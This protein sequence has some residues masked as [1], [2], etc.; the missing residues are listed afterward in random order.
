LSKIF[1]SG[2]EVKY[3]RVQFQDL[4][5]ISKGKGSF[6]VPRFPIK[7]EKGKD[8]EVEVE[9]SIKKIKEPIAEKSL[10]LEVIKEEAH[11]KGKVA[12]RL[13]A[14]EKLHSATQAL[15]AG[16]EQI[17]CL[18]K[19]LLI[20]SKEDML[21]LIMA[22]VKR[23]IHTEIE[24]KGDIIVKTLTKALQA[25]V[26]ADKYYIR[27]HPEDLNIVTEKEPLFLASM[28][29]LQNIYFLADE[30]VSRGGCFAESQAGEVDA[31]IESQLN[32]I[33]EHLR[34]EIV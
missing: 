14:E 29:G 30:T 18:R 1:R 23:V 6:F 26:Q 7:P 9:T 4:E 3:A 33:Y 10:N 19:S 17:S 21:R 25:A 22:V 27:V 8:P 34:Q 5:T 24:E 15:G 32:E 20:K 2:S 28:K 11:A 12:G 13:E 16:L 31:T